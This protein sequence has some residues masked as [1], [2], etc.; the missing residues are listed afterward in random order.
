MAIQL[1][2]YS[3]DSSAS[4]YTDL[5]S[6]GRIDLY[7][8]DSYSTNTT[9]NDTSTLQVM[10][11]YG[12]QGSDGAY[13]YYADLTPW[14]T[15]ESHQAPIPTSYGLSTAPI[16]GGV[17]ATYLYAEDYQ[18]NQISSLSDFSRVHNV[19]YSIETEQVD[20]MET[21]I[22]VDFSSNTATFGT[23]TLYTFQGTDASGGTS[24][25]WTDSDTQLEGYRGTTNPY[26][27][28]SDGSMGEGYYDSTAGLGSYFGT[29]YISWKQAVGDSGPGWYSESYPIS[30]WLGSDSISPQMVSDGAQG[31]GYYEHKAGSGSY[32]GEYSSS[33]RYAEMGT[34]GEGWYLYDNVGSFGSGSYS[35]DGTYEFLGSDSGYQIY[36]SVGY[37][38]S[39]IGSGS[40]LG[41]S[42]EYY[43]DG[44]Y[45]SGWYASGSMG[46]GSFGSYYSGSSGETL[47]YGSSSWYG[48]GYYTEAAGSGWLGSEAPSFFQGSGSWGGSYGYWTDSFEYGSGSYAGAG[49]EYP[50]TQYASTGPDGA[51]Y[52]S[53]EYGSGEFLGGSWPT[54]INDSSGSMGSVGYYLKT[55]EQGDG[56]YAGDGSM[57]PYHNN[58]DSGSMGAG[59]YS[60]TYGSGDYH[61][62]NSSWII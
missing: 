53:E 16:T 2:L 4:E 5:D 21:T 60:S 13:E 55:G 17:S 37:Y 33:F 11:H 15:V 43:S 42:P 18:G 56:Y 51:G 14:V 23:G 40:F 49:S 9:Q 47:F 28:N 50:T 62:P 31:S 58:A 48:S 39:V 44:Y 61:G 45:G 25:Y 7:S 32:F 30:E 20:S 10:F 41:D 34:Y 54:I 26:D 29:E 38:D 59:Y 52:Y 6:N 57:Y 3:N 1:S 19:Y 35:D 22:N 46:N 12:V 24:G 27:Y 36:G 8:A